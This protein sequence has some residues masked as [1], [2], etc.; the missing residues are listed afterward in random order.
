M[1]A[2]N[3]EGGH[4]ADHGTG[5]QPHEILLEVMG[6]VW[7][8]ILADFDCCHTHPMLTMPIGCEVTLDAAHRQALLM[9]NPLDWFAQSQKHI[10]RRRCSRACGERF[11]GFSAA[12]LSRS[13]R[14]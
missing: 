1:D 14:P 3:P 10:P 8:P 11:S 4:T 13:R 2:R 7:I 6:D 5:R 9:E 12:F